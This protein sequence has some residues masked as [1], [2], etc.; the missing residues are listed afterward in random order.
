MAPDAAPSFVWAAAIPAVGDLLELGRD[1]AHYLSR[2]CRVRP[3]DHVLATDGRGAVA[4][5]EVRSSGR[6]VTGEVRTLRRD[7]R[8]S[9]A[10]L[11]CGAPEGE[12]AD[13]MVEKL[14]ELGIAVCQ[15]VDCERAS[16]RSA[17]DRIERWRRL[18][19]AALRQ[20]RQS[21]EMEVR[22]PL[23]LGAFL[24]GCP[25]GSACWFADPEG[26]SWRGAPGDAVLLVGPAQGLSESEKGR[27]RTAG[28][29]AI[30]LGPS[31]LRTETAAIA[32]AALW[33][34]G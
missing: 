5:I 27:V 25:A 30:S 19:R 29:S 18:A 1:E 22:E 10:I 31:R 14:A 21:W 13:W 34:A 8:A 32:A 15:P 9:Q 33:R 2:V 12:R 16:W 4:E 7:A 20:S 24:A 26:G 3:G 11:A 17:S 6:A 28:F 23:D